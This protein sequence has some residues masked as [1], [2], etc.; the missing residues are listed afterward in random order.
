MINK[1]TA[2][3]AIGVARADSSA[4]FEV[5]DSAKGMLIPRMNK[6]NRLAINHPAEGLTVFQTDE[7]K[8]YWYYD[9]T[10]WQS[11]ISQQNLN[12]NANLKRLQTQIYLKN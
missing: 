11:I 7:E 5:K 8:G 1:S 2:Q 10:L 3:V 12:N 4:I 6:A 9:G